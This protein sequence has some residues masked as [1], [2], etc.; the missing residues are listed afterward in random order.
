MTCLKPKY[1]GRS[2]LDKSTEACSNSTNKPENIKGQFNTMRWLLAPFRLIFCV[3]SRLLEERFTLTAAALSF[4][5]LLGLVPMIA[6]G[7]GLLMY[8]PFFSGMA[9]VLEKFI[10]ANLL[11]E[12]AGAVIANYLGQ[13]AHRAVVVPWLG[14]IAL[15]ATALMQ[16]L[17]IEHAFNT[18][19][20][21][22][23]RRHFLRRVAMH[24]FVLLLGPLLFGGSLALITFI[25]SISFGFVDQ[26]IW[27]SATFFR[28][29]PVLFMAAL[30]TL[31][32]WGV[33]NKNISRWHALIG[34]VFASI[35][36][37]ALQRLFTLY[38]ANF[39]LYA[40]MYG[41]FSAVPIFLVWLYLSWGV[42][43]LGALIVAELPGV[44]QR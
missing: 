42:I 17:T 18:I 5:S 41:A 34:G 3:T 43:L 1:L 38:I 27:V 39:P 14:G 15:L 4:N 44:I 13:F 28:V 8:F 12:K 29:L 31:L 16:T 11:P 30:F 20:H 2:I 9:S 21:I 25:A 6:V 24:L 40:M 33:P 32:Y 35:A 10:L 37:V 7:L 23:T 36:F 26:P 19:W 22:K